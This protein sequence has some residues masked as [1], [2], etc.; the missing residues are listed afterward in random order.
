VGIRESLNENSSTV[1]KCTIGVLILAIVLAVIHFWPSHHSA[2]AAKEFFSDDDGTTW[3]VDDASQK[4]PFTDK[5]GKEAV[6]A[7]VFVTG[8]G[9][10]FVGYLEKSSPDAPKTDA[11]EPPHHGGAKMVPV[12]AVPVSGPLFKKPHDSKWVTAADPDYK[13]VIQVHSPDGK[14]DFTPVDPSE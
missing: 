4:A 12:D 9:Q 7:K 11:V 1:V 10:K 3:F 14:D 13:Q 5:N 6:L 2:A 8:G